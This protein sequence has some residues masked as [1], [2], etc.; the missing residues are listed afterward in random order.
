MSVAVFGLLSFYFT[1]FFLLVK[2]DFDVKFLLAEGMV[3]VEKDL[4]YDVMLECAAPIL[5]NIMIYN[6]CVSGITVS[7]KVSESNKIDPKLLLERTIEV[8][9]GLSYLSLELS[10]CILTLSALFRKEPV[11]PAHFHPENP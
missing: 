5:R 6:I 9:I 1:F 4:D 2:D 8:D 3:I 7:E 11:H 10:V